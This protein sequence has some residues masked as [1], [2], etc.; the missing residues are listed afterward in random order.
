MRR[1]LAVSGGSTGSSEAGAAELGAVEGNA[2]MALGLSAE[3]S[4]RVRRAT[5]GACA[6]ALVPGAST[7]DADRATRPKA[8][9][10]RDSAR[11][12]T[13]A[14]DS[15]AAIEHGR[16]SARACGRR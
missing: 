15:R 8:T 6:A 1:S 9:A 7:T 12:W 5:A 11:P 2:S 16:M 13:G 4:E 10:G 14:Q 3:Q